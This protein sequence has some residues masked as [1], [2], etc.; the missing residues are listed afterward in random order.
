MTGNLITVTSFIVAIANY[1]TTGNHAIA[2]ACIVASFIGLA[3]FVAEIIWA[4]R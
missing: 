1:A 3:V 2:Y 4:L